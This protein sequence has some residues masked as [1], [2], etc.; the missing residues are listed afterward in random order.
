MVV[1]GRYNNLT[2]SNRI[3]SIFPYSTGGAEGAFDAL[4]A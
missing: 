2:L 3:V 4:I 1:D